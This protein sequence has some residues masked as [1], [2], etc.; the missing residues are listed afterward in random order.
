[1]YAVKAGLDRSSC[2]SNS[3][4]PQLDSIADI[5]SAAAIA[6][7]ELNLVQ[8]LREIQV[9][10][11]TWIRRGG[12]TVFRVSCGAVGANGPSLHAGLWYIYEK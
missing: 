5:V 3:W 9:K 1:M 8:N 10:L 7:N 6:D 11:T 12:E 4:P 2:S